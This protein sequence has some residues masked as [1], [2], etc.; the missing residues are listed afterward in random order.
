MAGAL[1]RDEE[2][3]HILGRLDLAEVDV[4]AVG[5]QQGFALGQMGPDVV[6]IDR[7]LHFVG[8]QN[9]DQIGLLGRFGGGHG[10]EAVFFGQLVV[11]AAGALAHDHLDPGIPQVLGMGMALAAV[12]DDGDGLIFQN[13]EIGILIIIH[14]HLNIL[15]N[16]SRLNKIH[17]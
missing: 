2:D 9:H 11:G 17:P 12:A 3:I 5:E 15:C 13:I 8:Q 7:R 10:R 1:G 6:F 4:E 16:R 14:F